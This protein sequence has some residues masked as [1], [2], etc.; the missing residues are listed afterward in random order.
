MQ[1]EVAKTAAQ[2]A[3]T[4]EALQAALASYDAIL[5]EIDESGAWELSV[6]K[7]RA[8]DTGSSQP[9]GTVVDLLPFGAA[10]TLN[11]RNAVLAAQ[12]TYKAKLDEASAALAA[13]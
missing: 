9:G 11:T 10:N 12:A 3:T 8:K 7:I 6:C 5:A 1:I 13:L 4:I 2:L